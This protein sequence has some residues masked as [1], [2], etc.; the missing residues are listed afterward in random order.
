MPPKPKF[1][2]E[3]VLETAFQLVREQGVENL[4]ARSI[5]KMLN[6]SVQP[7]FSYYE[8]MA[9]LKTDLFAMVNE[10]HSRYFDKVVSDE[11]FFSNVGLAYI[12]FAIEEPNL[13]KLLFMTN[14]FEGMQL[15]QFVSG[16]CN[17]HITDAIPDGFNQSISESNPVFTD[18]WL[19]AH[20]IASMIVMNQISFER[21]EIESMIKN[22]FSLLVSGQNGGHNE[23]V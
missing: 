7:V 23:S 11:N 17:E 5:A 15:N 3:L 6:S 1:N 10:Y 21:S 22:M 14:S 4:N 12:C 13:F 20:G 18:M 8:N 16:E 2:K 9:D 19:Y